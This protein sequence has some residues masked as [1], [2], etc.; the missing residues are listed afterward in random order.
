MTGQKTGWFY[1]QTANRRLAGQLT[2]GLV[3]QGTVV[4]ALDVCS[5]LG[6]F[7]LAMAAAG[8]KSVWLIDR[9][10]RALELAATS[11]KRN[12]LSERVRLVQGDAFQT[13]SEVATLDQHFHNALG[14]NAFCDAGS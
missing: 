11:A 4:T 10:E 7:G 13:L 8:A 5:Y 1:D 14:R 6:G 3:E 9:S 12:R 2:A